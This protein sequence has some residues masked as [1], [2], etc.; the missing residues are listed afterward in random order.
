MGNFSGAG[1]EGAAAVWAAA[2][3]VLLP[4]WACGPMLDAVSLGE[5]RGAML[6]VDEAK[7][8]RLLLCA[9]SLGTAAAVSRFG[10]REIGRAS[11]R[12]RV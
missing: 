1:P 8:R 11:C 7:L 9:A 3:L 4:A 6:G 12:E 5:G 10:S 2:A